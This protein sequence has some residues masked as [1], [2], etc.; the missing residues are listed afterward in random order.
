MNKKPERKNESPVEP[1]DLINTDAIL[2]PSEA[3]FRNLLKHIPG[4]SIQGYR[5]DGTVVY[6]NKASEEIYG[7][8]SRE[9]IGKYLGDLIIPPNLKP[10]FKKSLQEGK[11]VKKSGEF[12]P[13]GELMLLHKDG[14]LVPVYSIHTAVC[15]EGA[16]PMLFCIDVDL[17]ERKKVEEAIKRAKQEWEQTFDTIPDLIMI[18]D[19]QYRI[20]RANRSMA[21]KVGIPITEISGKFCYRV[22][23][24]T[25]APP[26]F[27]P[28]TKLLKD[29]REHSVEAC[30]DLL[31][32]D[33]L[34]TTTPLHDRDGRLTGA[35]HVARDITGMKKVE[36]ELRESE[37]RM[38]LAISGAR[39]GLWDQDI[40]T[41]ETIHN[42]QWAE[43]L[44]YTLEEI[45]TENI[46][47]ENL[48]HPDDFLPALKNLNDHLAGKTPFYEAEYR[49]RT[50]TGEW[51][52]I[53]SAG[54]VSEW[55]DSGKPL[56]ML[57]T[58]RD[59]SYR[60]KAEGAKIKSE[61]K[62]RSLF[63][64]SLDAIM[65]LSPPDWRFT[66]GNPATLKMFGARDEE[67][68]TSIGPWEVSPEYQPDGRLSA[69][70]AKNNISKAMEV[71]SAYF[72]WTHKKLSG[73]EFFATVLLTRFR[74]EDKDILQATVRD[75][76]ERKEMENKLRES[77]ERLE[78]AVSG[79]NL[80]LWDEDVVTG[81]SIRN[82]QWYEVIDYGPKEV[83]LRTDAW[84]DLIHPDDVEMVLKL[85]ND[86]LTGK[87]DYYDAEYRMKT[88]AG[89][90]RWVHSTGRVSKRDA[91]GEP[92][93]I[94]GTHRDISEHKQ[95]EE[96]LAK[97]RDN[98]EDLIKDRTV[99]LQTLVGAMSG[100]EARMADLKDV[101]KLLRE[102]IEEAGMEPVADDPLL[103]GEE[104]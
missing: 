15:T 9:A 83:E 57:G 98:L 77:E 95:S 13:P 80:G 96:E 62:Y 34:I 40:A 45:E 33:Y 88:K 35:V 93:R 50:R 43:M 7:Y 60:K 82:H 21:D 86:H 58:Q 12:G 87:S 37:E 55:D 44:G 36:N 16:E 53:Q 59:I 28:N 101:I 1:D 52:W 68:F 89:E 78:L 99:E 25:E 4:V 27:C 32:G 73:E 49:M 61:S 81:K 41:G 51:K 76:T 85:Y 75:V 65:T 84:S 69:E 97:Y 94:I 8:T 100:R 54:S 18:V 3:R 74:F 24:G 47:W 91:A 72:E 67:E 11:K 5:P 42:R 104:S 17:S 19:D 102:Q 56:R 39:L 46:N 70:L 92:L 64:S 103:G 63:D 66:S 29:G 90:W 20:V 23:H 10:L 2:H 30:L 38:E 6:W 14:R 79:T 71:G 26:D 22:V 48:L 31:G